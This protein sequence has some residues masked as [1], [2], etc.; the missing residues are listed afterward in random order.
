MRGGAQLPVPDQG[1]VQVQHAALA[2]LE[3]LVHCVV[4]QRLGPVQQLAVHPVLHVEGEVRGLHEGEREDDGAGERPPLRVAPGQRV[5]AEHGLVGGGLLA[6]RRGLHEL[7]C[8]GA[9]I[10]LEV[11]LLHCLRI[12]RVRQ[13]RAL[14]RSHIHV[15][16]CLGCFCLKLIHDSFQVFLQCFNDMDMVWT[17]MDN[18]VT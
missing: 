6:T 9:E 2:E 8:P 14:I 5:A 15:F 13:H 11:E 10:V 4:L 17:K 18:A 7:E 16:M 3:G 1:Q 12:P